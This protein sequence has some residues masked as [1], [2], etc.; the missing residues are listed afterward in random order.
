[1]K[2]F[3][4]Y[5]QVDGMRGCMKK[6]VIVHAKQMQK[7]FRVDTMEGNY[8][9]GKPGDYLMRGIE[10]ELYICDR[11]IFEKTYGWIDV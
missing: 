2:T 5:E 10:G 6:P 4:T 8:K 11:D 9:Q 3:E 1:V 7:G